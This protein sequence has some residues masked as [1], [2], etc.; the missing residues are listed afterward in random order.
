MS[1]WR[2]AGAAFALV[3]RT[4]IAIFVLYGL[5]FTASFTALHGVDLQALAY[6]NPRKAYL[7]RV[8]S[9]L[10][11]TAWVLI[12]V[13]LFSDWERTR[14]AWPPTRKDRMVVVFSLVLGMPFVVLPLVAQYI[15]WQEDPIVRA[16]FSTAVPAVHSPARSLLVNLTGLASGVLLGSV[17]LGLH[18]Q[19]IDRLPE[20]RRRA[21]QSEPGGLEED[22]RW[23][24]RCR[25][26]LGLFLALCGVVMGSSILSVSAIRHLL[27]ETLPPNAVLPT[28]PILGYGIYYT[29]LLAS[30]YLPAYRSLKNV[31]QTLTERLARQS[32]PASA[33][34]KQR[35]E[36]R[37]AARTWL[38][39]QGSAL[40][41]FQQGLSIFTP[42]LASISSLI[43]GPID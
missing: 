41:D 9:A 21:E 32:L 8:L 25:E 20:L 40:Q 4:P 37:E 16:A 10:A 2:D 39:L 15:V 27:N 31:G 11:P 3:F 29:G 23:Y 30:A 36:E 38:G 18:L 33:T 17:I 43:L 14:S 35:H 6:L 26:L 28:S 42:L 19:L 22:V 5:A 24:Q 1:F 13:L 7:W 34:C 12:L